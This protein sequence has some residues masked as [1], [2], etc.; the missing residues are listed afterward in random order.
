MPI[1]LRLSSATAGGT[2]DATSLGGRPAATGPSATTGA[3]FHNLTTAQNDAGHTDYVCLFVYNSGTTQ[4]NNVN[5]TVSNSGGGTL[6]TAALS[7]VATAAF[8]SYVTAVIASDT[9]APAV[10]GSFVY[11]VAV[12]NLAAGQVKAVWLKRVL[13]VRTNP[14]TADRIDMVISAQEVIPEP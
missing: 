14:V 2:A 7:S 3:F 5:L 10:T 12:G 9:T 6:V 11:T 1:S 4:M 8:A 13:G